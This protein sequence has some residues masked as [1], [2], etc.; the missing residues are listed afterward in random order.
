MNSFKSFALLLLGL[1]ASSRVT[2][3]QPST[4]TLESLLHEMTDTTAIAR[5]P[6][7]H[8]TCKQASS[9]DRAKVAPDKP[10]WFGNDDHTQFIRTENNA[11][12]HEQVM[13]DV[14]GPGALVRF[15]LTSGKPKHGTLRIYLDGD[16]APTLTF[17][18]FDLL[19]GALK[20]P[21]SL[22]Q[23]HPAYS[24]DFGGNNLYLPFPMP[25]IAKSPGRK[26][27]SRGRATTI[28]T[29][30]PTLLAPRSKPSPSRNSKRR[31][32]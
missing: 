30:A 29:I 32:T 2:M 31:M 14:D 15:W 17:Q 23:A 11:G 12:R 1:V 8:F 25:S 7:P 4:V 28:S 9:H 16:A 3:A 26:G 13:L 18:D 27:R 10:G 24:P 19:G 22:L 5:W 20:L 6:E 21:T